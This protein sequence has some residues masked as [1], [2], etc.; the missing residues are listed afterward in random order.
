[1]PDLGSMF[2][3]SVCDVQWMP[4]LTALTNLD[5]MFVWDPEEYAGADSG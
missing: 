5:L 3:R 1:M 4:Q 2:V